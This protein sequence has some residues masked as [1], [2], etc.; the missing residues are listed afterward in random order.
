MEDRKNPRAE[1]RDMNPQSDES[2]SEMEKEKLLLRKKRLNKL[3]MPDP[4]RSIDFE[5]AEDSIQIVGNN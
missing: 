5:P 2:L 3:K 1:W 4:S